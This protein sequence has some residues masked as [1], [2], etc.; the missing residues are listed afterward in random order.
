MHSIWNLQHS[1]LLNTHQCSARKLK[2]IWIWFKIK[3]PLSKLFIYCIG[4]EEESPRHL[5]QECHPHQLS[6]GGGVW[7]IRKNIMEERLKI[8]KETSSS[9]D[10]ISP[11]S[12]L[13]R[14]RNGSWLELN[15]E[16]RW[17]HHK[18]LRLPSA[19]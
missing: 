4:E 10:V 17:H 14:H 15:L 12:S 2:L 18:H 13:S 8:L 19:L 7:V 11:S 5:A 16:G 6:R 1:I 3:F 9:N